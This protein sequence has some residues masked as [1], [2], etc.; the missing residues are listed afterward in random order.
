MADE[1]SIADE[2]TPMGRDA[3][4]DET[5]AGNTAFRAGDLHSALQHYEQA[6]RGLGSEHDDMAFSLYENL[7]LVRMQFGRHHAAIRAFMRALDGVPTSR[8]QSLRFLLVS[9]LQAGK[10]QDASRLMVTYQAAFGEHPEP[11]VRSAC[12]V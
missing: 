11:F 4:I 7:A 1:H 10:Q 5:E 2:W 9:L 3:V 8:E 12:G 6:A